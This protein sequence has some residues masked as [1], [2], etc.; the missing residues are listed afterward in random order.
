MLG[1]KID[2]L[3]GFVEIVIKGFEFII[4]DILVIN[5]IRILLV[6]FFEL[7]CDNILLRIFFVILIIF[8]YILLKWEV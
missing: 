6:I 8:F 5:V 7:V 2:G 3:L 1:V 4:E